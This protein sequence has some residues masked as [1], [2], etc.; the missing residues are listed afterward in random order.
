MYRWTPV[1]LTSQTH[2]NEKHTEHIPVQYRRRAERIM[3]LT[4]LTPGGSNE[5]VRQLTPGVSYEALRLGYC[6]N[7]NY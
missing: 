2:R 7:V 6:V 3:L 1:S 5:S 4:E